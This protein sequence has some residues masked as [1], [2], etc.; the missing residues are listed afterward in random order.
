[1]N[2]AATAGVDPGEF[3]FLSTWYAAAEKADETDLHTQVQQISELFAFRTVLDAIPNIVLVLNRHRQLVYNNRALLEFL[4][5]DSN[6]S[7]IGQRPGDFLGCIHSRELQSGCGTTE[8]CSTCGAVNAILKTHQGQSAIEE[9]Q[10]QRDA[11]GVIEALD[12]RVQATPFEHRGYS[13][14]IFVINDIGHEKRRAILERLFYHDI[15]NTAGVIYGASELLL[16]STSPRDELMQV[17]FHCSRQLTDEINAHRDLTY[18]ENGLL[19]IKLATIETLPFIHDMAALYRNHDQARHKTIA[20]APHSVN[21]TLVSDASL[22]GR[23]IGNMLKNALEAT[24]GGATVT[25]GCHPVDKDRVEFWVH[26]PGSMPRQIQ[27]QLFQRSFSTKD[28]R[29]GLGTYSM[30]LFSEKYL[31]GRVSFVSTIESGTTFRAQ[32]PVKLNDSV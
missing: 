27:L 25:I 7:L 23:V 11:N 16:E 8:F 15:L 17:I 3:H 5:L 32:Y 14:T 22:L 18:A 29:R 19:K 12:L 9:C 24:P 13:Y 1:M 28:A 26:N 2:N 10:I 30:K 31:Q 20:I 4:N 21:T 6:Q